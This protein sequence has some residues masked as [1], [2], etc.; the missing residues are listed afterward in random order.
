MSLCASALGRAPMRSAGCGNGV[1]GRVVT[2]R[3]A[4]S[5]TPE[6]GDTCGAVRGNNVAHWGAE[7]NYSERLV[8]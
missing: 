7:L 8:E 3:R 1:R 2:C 4:L 6:R 5:T